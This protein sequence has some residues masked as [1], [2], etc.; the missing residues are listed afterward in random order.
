MKFILEQIVITGVADMILITVLTGDNNAE[1]LAT[2][3]STSVK[4]A[5]N[6]K[7]NLVVNWM[8]ITSF[9]SVNL[10]KIAFEKQTRY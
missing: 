10:V 6:L 8:S 3:T 2:E 4:V 7:M 1:T 5:A 9:P